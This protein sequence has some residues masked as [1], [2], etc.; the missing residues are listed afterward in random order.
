M[1]YALLSLDDE[2]IAYL[3]SSLKNILYN[4]TTMEIHLT[5]FRVSKVVSSFKHKIYAIL[6]NN[7]CSFL[8]F[9]SVTVLIIRL[10]D[11]I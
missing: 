3:V 1:D 7:K 8:Q 6:E 5:D 4:P 9:F 11:I 10:S 2:N